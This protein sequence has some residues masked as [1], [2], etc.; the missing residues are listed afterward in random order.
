[1]DEKLS[2][3][4]AQS[5]VSFW[6]LVISLV[7]GIWAAYAVAA[8]A[9]NFETLALGDTTL[10]VYGSYKGDK[11]FC[12]SLDE[13]PQCLDPA[14]KRALAKRV[15]WLGNSQ[16]H[17]INQPKPTDKTAPTLLAESLRPRGTEVIGFSFPSASL[18]EMLVAYDFMQNDRKVDVLV[19][20]AFLDDTREQTTRGMLRPAIENKAIAARLNGSAVGIELSRRLEKSEDKEVLDRSSQS[21]QTRSENWLTNLLE[22]CCGL[23][24]ARSNARGQI[25]IQ[26]FLF[27]NW[28]FS[29]TAQTVRPIIPEAYH[30]NMAAL[31]EI[32]KQAHENGTQVILYIPPLRQD[33]SPPYDPEQYR[34]FKVETEVLA[35]RYG[36]RWINVEALVPGHYWGTK[37]ST[38]TGGGSELDFM[39]YQGAGHMLLEK[40]LAPAIESALK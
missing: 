26:A 18:A 6:M 25:A 33:F 14:R 2:T 15:V 23:Q 28:L 40:A 11:I 35:K 31:T 38:R 7:I 30:H 5:A 1:M 34:A 29:V 22:D 32:L 37:A 12:A 10:G 17:A 36:A 4:R 39:H 24:T 8:T 16:L 9:P 3:P 27:R 19:L 21:L 13:M 20:P